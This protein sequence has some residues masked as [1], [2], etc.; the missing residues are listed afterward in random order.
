MSDNID[1]PTGET[2]DD[3]VQ[4]AVNAA[5][6]ISFLPVKKKKPV[7]DLTR[8]K[9]LIYGPPKIGKSTLASHF[10]GAWFLATEEGLDWLEVYEPTQITDWEQ[11]LTVCAWIEET[12][13]TTFGDGSPIGTIVIDTVDLLFKM[14]CDYICMQLGVASLADLDWGKGWQAVSDEFARVICK[15]TRWPYGTIFISHSKEQEIKSGKTKVDWIKPATMTTGYRI[16]SALVDIIAYCCV[17]ETSVVDDA[18]ELTGEIR[19]T[20]IIRCAP[21]N[22][23]IAGDRTSLLPDTIPLSYKKLV[24]YFPD[25]PKQSVTN[26]VKKSK[27]SK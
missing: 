3:G 12:R 11:F 20:R 15:I 18:G 21:G 2:T 26:Q 6:T 9:I 24:E 16:L 19:E 10:P 7:A 17:E 4:A 13:P 22:N 1:A 5:Q 14:A 23:I 25:T 8:A 27:K